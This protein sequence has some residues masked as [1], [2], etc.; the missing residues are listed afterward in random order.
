MKKLF[1]IFSIL[2]L[3]NNIYSQPE[4]WSDY[5]NWAWSGKF[6]PF[7]KV[8]IGYG[9]PGQNNFTGGFS[10]IGIADLELGY[11]EYKKYSDFVYRLDDRHLFGSYF[12]SGAAVFGENEPRD[13]DTEGWRVGLGHNIGYG[14]KVWELS[15]IPY[16]QN[17]F[18]LTSLTFSE[19]DSISQ[20]D[21]D[22]LTRLEGDARFGVSTE[23]GVRL[24]VAES[25]SLNA[26][27]EGA[28]IFPRFVVLSW[29]GSFALQAIS[30]NLVSLFSESIVKSSPI[31]GPIM[32]LLLRNAITFAWFYA[33]KDQ[34][35]WP[36]E[37]E[38]PFTL[39]TIKLGA[40]ITF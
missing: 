17:Q 20:S 26:S 25:I 33:L 32:Y 24:Y 27:F 16:N 34:Q 10:S 12:T 14:Y 19:R 11:S 4:D 2:I 23:G 40:S 18:T 31:F 8:N 7:M 13:V 39:E 6:S 3:T 15:L 1:V 37:S 36:I 35:Y 30:V 28:V 21:E 38:T 22:I 5:I 9:F 29:I